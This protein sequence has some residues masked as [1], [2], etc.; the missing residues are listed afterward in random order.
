MATRTIPDDVQP[1]WSCTVNG[2]KYTYRSG[3]TVNVPDSVAAVIDAINEGKKRPEPEYVPTLPVITEADEG[4]VPT[5]AGG[6][7]VLAGVST[8]PLDVNVTRTKDSETDKDVLTLDKT[9]EE[10]YEAVS[11][12]RM[13]RAMMQVTVPLGDGEIT[14]DVTLTGPFSVQKLD[15]GE[16]VSYVVMLHTG[17]DDGAAFFISDMIPADATVVLK[18]V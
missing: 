14:I 12:G 16:G 2:K 6:R 8:A 13:V 10:L 7:Y 1:Y 4:K 11:A 3:E 9:A 17:S 5:A 18:E 15:A